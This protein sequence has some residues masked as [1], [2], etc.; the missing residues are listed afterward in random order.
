[1]SVKCLAQGHNQT[2]QWPRWG[3]NPGPPYPK[4]NALPTELSGQKKWWGD[5]VQPSKV[6]YDAVRMLRVRCD[7][8]C[9]S[10]LYMYVRCLRLLRNKPV[11]QSASTA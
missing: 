2:T 4:T 11:R 1:M 9:Y 3:L 7:T 10:T 6:R 8:L 5:T